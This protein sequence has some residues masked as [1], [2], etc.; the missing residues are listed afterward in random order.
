MSAAQRILVTGG[1]G[2]IGRYVVDKLCS[3][4]TEPIVTTSGEPGTIGVDS[5]DLVALDL[6]DAN[7]TDRVISSNKP[8]I[9]LHLGGVTGT[10]A[11]GD[12]CQAVNYVGTVNLLTS[13][14]KTGVS[15]VILLGTAAEYGHQPTPFREDMASRPV[16]SYAVSK[17]KANEFALEMHSSTGFPVTILR[18]FTAYGAGQ[19]RKMFLPQVITH[20]LLKQQFRM[21]DG[22]Q[23]RDF[24]FVGDV[25]DAIM[26]ALATES[27]KGRVI[28]IAGGRGIALNDLAERVWDL[29][30][31]GRELLHI[32]S[33][34]KASDD[35]FDTEADISL[36]ADLL[37]WRPATPFIGDAADG[38]PLV[39]MI[40]KKKR[41]LESS[42]SA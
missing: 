9:V 35:A 34:E 27:S 2:F 28:N 7:A 21:S 25:V 4:G 12:R 26:A 16:S 22:R 32:G 10:G 6:T 17:A 5:R 19:P 41:E 31:A 8:D 37:G 42:A 14:E 39:A 40:G 36:A 15:H 1:T 30:G 20:A 18:V 3:L 11:S 29:C 24:V 13:L 38:H 23:K 33:I